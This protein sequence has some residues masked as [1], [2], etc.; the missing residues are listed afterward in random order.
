MRRRRALQLAGGSLS[1]S[2]AGCV[3]IPSLNTDSSPSSP[4]E[5]WRVALDDPLAGRPAVAPQNVL[6]PAPDELLAFSQETGQQHWQTAATHPSVAVAEGVFF[7]WT[8]G[9]EPELRVFGLDAYQPIW[10]TEDIWRM[11]TAV[12]GTAYLSEGDTSDA[13][14]GESADT[15]GVHAV[16][17][18]TGEP[19]WSVAV[20]GPER[21]VDVGA[22]TAYVWFTED[23]ADQS[24]GV[25]AV[26]V[27]DGSERWHTPTDRPWGPTTLAGDTLVVGSDD[28][29][30]GG[31]RVLGLDA[32][33]GDE[34][35]TFTA[36]G[37][38]TSAFPRLASDDHVVVSSEGSEASQTTMI[39]AAS[40]DVRWR[41]DNVDVPY[42]LADGLVFLVSAEGVVTAVDVADGTERW[43][44]DTAPGLDVNS[45][46]P[47][48]RLHDGGLYLVTADA[49]WALDAATG[50]VRWR[51]EPEG[52]AELTRDWAVGDGG[53]YL[54]TRQT[55]YAF[56]RE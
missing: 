3:A 52:E 42:A 32:T 19:R 33:D 4:T 13:E 23:S 46:T 40:G 7:L 25:S 15:G 28:A 30:D 39:D 14:T 51:F 44:F 49:A 47:G 53:V 54:A 16:D 29:A 11:P 12:D 50:E 45:L 9:T 26:A 22:D 27:A 48:V 41:K 24:R 31:G 8:P 38:A 34:R 10:E 5:R 43:T 56:E 18:Q 55:L 37:D 20:P 1:V 6:V 36:A 17:L 35:W 2:L 21:L